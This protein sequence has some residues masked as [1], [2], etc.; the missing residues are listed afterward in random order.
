[1]KVLSDPGKT[2]ALDTWLRDAGTVSAGGVSGLGGSTPGVSE[3]LATSASADSAA[4]RTEGPER[5]GLAAPPVVSQDTLAGAR[6]SA[7]VLLNLNTWSED[8]VSARRLTSSLAI[9][10]PAAMSGSL[11]IAQLWAEHILAPLL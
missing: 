5:P 4:S 7:E 3:S 8:E 1:M 10:T 2:S 9:P 11:S 6:D